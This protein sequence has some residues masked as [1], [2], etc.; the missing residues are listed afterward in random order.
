MLYDSIPVLM[1]H[2]VSPKGS[3]LNVYPHIFESQLSLL[4]RTGWH[5]LSSEELLN[6][7]LNKVPKPRRSIAITFDD[8]FA[9]NY[10]YALPILKKYNM[11]A[12]LF[13]CTEFIKDFVTSRD[14]FD[15]P[16]HKT[17]MNLAFTDRAHMVMCTWDEIKHME[18]SGI[19]D[20]QSHGISHQIPEY[21]R[22]DDYTQIR[23]DLVD[24]RKILMERLSKKIE[25]F[26]WPKGVYNKRLIKIA[27][28]AGYKALYT[29]K[30]GANR[31]NIKEIRRFP[32]KN[33]GD[34]WLLTKVFIYSSTLLSKLYVTLRTGI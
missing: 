17:S 33:R 16:T 3:E 34:R 2:H 28:E 30:R 11:K 7:M 29:T 15:P 18:D 8:G 27:E 13:V 24:S 21:L 12:I 1:Y 4:K 5:T 23:N 6:I 20:I 19:F 9:D 14:I 22:N 26:A 31:R 10:I 25:H 32:V